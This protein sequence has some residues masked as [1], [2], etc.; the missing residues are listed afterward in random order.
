MPFYPCLGEGSPTKIDYR[1]KGTL[2]LTS[3]LQDLADTGTHMVDGARIRLVGPRGVDKRNEQ[4][5]CDRSWGVPKVEEPPKW[6][7]LV[8]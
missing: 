8:G 6:L 3:L 7:N 2:I 1:K 5:R 4:A